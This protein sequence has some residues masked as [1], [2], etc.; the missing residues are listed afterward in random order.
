MAFYERLGLEFA[1]DN[2][3][4]VEAALGGG[5]VR[6]MLDS[7]ESVKGFHPG[8]TPPAGGGRS[9]IAFECDGPAEVDAVYVELTG[10]GGDGVLEPWDAPWG[11]RYASL[12]D[13]DGNGVDLYAPLPASG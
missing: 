13:P 6:F 4:H 11:Q 2:D 12:H 5:A 7:E 9:S 10:A 8:W 3:H 1:L